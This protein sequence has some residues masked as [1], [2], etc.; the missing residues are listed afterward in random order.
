[1]SSQLADE[2]QKWAAS[3]LADADLRLYDVELVGGVLRVTIE[4][5]GDG[6]VGLDDITRFSRG[7]SALLD[8]HDPIKS[9]YTLEVSS[10]GLERKLRT[11]AHWRGAVGETVRIKLRK[12]V[13]DDRRLSGKV[14][15]ADDTTVTVTD[16]SDT[17][18]HV[19][20]ADIDSARTVFAWEKTPKPG[21]PSPSKKSSSPTEKKAVS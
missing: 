18:I 14:D 8:T 3:L 21:K 2:I 1:M 20:L 16:D 7:L 11:P 13:A 4:R 5:D 17:E 15:R 10:P 12:G 19:A 6:G 9:G